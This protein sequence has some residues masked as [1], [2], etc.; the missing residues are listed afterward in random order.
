[1]GGG[2]PCIYAPFPMSLYNLKRP[3]CG[4]W[5]FLSFF[6][7]SQRVIWSIKGFLV[8]FNLCGERGDSMDNLSTNRLMTIQIKLH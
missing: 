2:K 7:S 4:A 3:K 5:A 1:M 8:L 6:A